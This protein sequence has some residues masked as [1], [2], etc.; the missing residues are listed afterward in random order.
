VALLERA[1]QL[2]VA[3]RYLAD[4]A[5][6][7]GRLVFVAGEAGVGKTTFV[8]AVVAAAAGSA[9]VAVGGCDGSATPVPLGPFVEMLPALPPDAW[10]PGVPRQ[11]FFA[12][13]VAALR[14]PPGPEPYLLVVEDAHWA[15]EATLD[16]IR[17]L[18]RRV[19]GC[20]ALVLVTYRPEDATSGHPL[21]IVVGDAATMTGTRRLDLPALTP[22]AVRA[23]VEEH[24][25]EHPDAAAADPEQLHR[26][27]G[28]N[29]FYVTEALSVGSAEVP[30]TVRD[31]V[32]SRTARLSP[33]ARQVM[34]VV[35]L[36][37]S[38]A[39]LDVLE[40]VLA[41]SSHAL[42]EP[43]ERGLLRVVG[44]E[45]VFR[46]ELAR[47]AVAEQ[48]PAFRRIAVHRQILA[49]L[50]ERAAAGP[51]V[52]P[53]RLAHHAEAAGD[54]DA[55]VG[56]APE[57]AA[58]AAALG[59]HREAVRQYRRVLRY[60]DRLPDLER[61]DLLWSLG[62]E[63][64][65]TDLIDEAIEATRGA[66]EIWEAAGDEVRVGDSY[67]CLSRLS[68]FAGRNDVAEQQAAQAVDVLTGSGGESV[69]LAMAYS[70]RAQLRMLSS[71]LEGT[72]EWSAR[73]LDLLDQLPEGPARTEVTVH[74][75]TNLGT[76]EGTSGDFATGLDLLTSSLA[77]ARAGDLH[78]HAARAYCNLCALAVVQRRHADAQTHLAAGLEYCIDRDLDAWTLYLQGFRARLL[79][80]R[81]ETA[82]AAR[83][84]T[85]T[86]RRV[87]LTPVGRIEPLIALA[88]ARGRVGDPDATAALD[89]AAALAAD[90]GEAQRLG[91][92]GQA[93][94]ELA[95]LAGDTATVARAAAEV[96]PVVQGADCPWNRGSIATWL[97]DDVPVDPARLA[98][99]YALEVT[100]RWREAADLWGELG[101][102]FERGLAL[103]RSGEQEGL[104]EA[105]GVFDA[106][107]AEAAAAR[108][109]ALLRARGWPAP[110]RGAAG[111][112][113]HPA[114]L[115]GREV[116]VLGLLAEG[117]TDAGIAERL[118]ISRRTVEHHVASILAKLGVRSR[119]EAAAKHA[120][121]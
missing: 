3:G 61:A 55:V 81:G 1:E 88:R 57:A 51:A 44:G 10:P 5:T 31:A 7:N 22:D 93:R 23:L 121:G 49:A 97:D 82:D 77:Q 53:A 85:D 73:A 47:R 95:W 63:C 84:A 56:Y 96:W 42:D 30:P 54:G 46:H 103:A 117:L 118:V 71:D 15:D 112:P 98:P 116:E 33:Q 113:R 76:S 45:V 69:E 18:A 114:G 106:L 38:R 52:D 21:R 105:V 36:A 4:A 78:E 20:R 83:L 70:N 27:T 35:A 72:R 89:R 8:D 65:L 68:W 50:R 26:V 99:P 79:L 40:R 12:R 107:D 101:S 16:L 91:P 75:L 64:Y 37:G 80:D 87:S 11:E 13:L 24:A 62:Y 17:H 94:S 104:T 66:L 28:G 43:L 2:R 39:E 14:N 74:A 86:L 102:P 25:R 110:R 59:S 90:I 6:G 29:A 58:R 19:H 111:T 48:V 119:H 67:R 41:D 92:V 115:T 100:G 9:R 109:R 34:D 120:A 60:A 32:L 108:A